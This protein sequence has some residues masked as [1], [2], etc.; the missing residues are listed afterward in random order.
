MSFAGSIVSLGRGQCDFKV[1]GSG[2]AV[3]GT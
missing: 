1:E 2:G 3:S